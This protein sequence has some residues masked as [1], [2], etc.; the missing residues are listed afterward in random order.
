MQK[1]LINVIKNIF[2]FLDA[3]AYAV[4]LLNSR[5]R[6]KNNF[7]E[8]YELMLQINPKSVGD[9]KSLKLRLD[10]HHSKGGKY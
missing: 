2:Q 1:L 8:V 5:V 3:L 10:V 6:K 9:F 7:S 4:I